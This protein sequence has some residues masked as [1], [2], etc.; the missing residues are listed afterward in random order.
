MDS[1]L[2]LNER[3]LHPCDSLYWD[4]SCIICI[5]ENLFVVKLVIL[6]LF[7]GLKFLTQIAEQQRSFFIQALLTL[8]YPICI[9]WSSGK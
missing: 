6:M 8:F 1:Y 2:C 5:L 4:T 3:Y 9:R 7:V